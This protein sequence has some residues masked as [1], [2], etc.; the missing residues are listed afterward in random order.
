MIKD[1]WL[2]M[3]PPGCG[4]GTQATRFKAEGFAEHLS[5]G[6]LLRASIKSQSALGL[7]VQGFVDSGSLVPDEVMLDVFLDAVDC[8]KGDVPLIL[9]GYPRTLA[10]GRSLVETVATKS[11]SLV[12]AGVFWFKLNA[13]ILVERAVS[14]RICSHCGAIY[15]LQF[16]APRV[17]GICDLCSSPLLHR[18]DDTEETILKRIEIYDNDTQPLLAFLKSSTQVITLDADRPETIIF[19]EILG[20]LKK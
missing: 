16:K 13:S 20:Y 11:D 7:K 18:K 8:L 10:Q 6:D 5:T 3:G 19:E 15:N 2:F 12:L 9:D 1:L 17:D 14:R 4:K